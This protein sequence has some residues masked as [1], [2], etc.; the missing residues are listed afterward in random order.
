M[1]NSPESGSQNPS[2]VPDPRSFGKAPN[3]EN[4][5]RY[6]KALG[7]TSTGNPVVYGYMLD[8]GLTLLVGVVGVLATQYDMI[9]F[10]DDGVLFLGMDLTSHFTGE[11]AF[12][13]FAD[14]EKI[15][16]KGFGLSYTLTLSDGDNTMKVKVNRFIM[17]RPWQ[18]TN[19]KIL[20]Q[21]YH[22]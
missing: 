21:R 6:R 1:T 16:F 19:V 22:K 9:S 4:I 8:T 5:D 13:K 10:E 17:G 12:I 20:A 14:L 7:Y 15:T 18:G 11:N 2:Q 3:L